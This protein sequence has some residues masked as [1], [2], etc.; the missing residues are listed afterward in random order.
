MQEI[1]ISNAE[2]EDE[3]EQNAKFCHELIAQGSSHSEAA[4]I[5]NEISK[6]LE[7]LEEA[8]RQNSSAENAAPS[9]LP[10]NAQDQN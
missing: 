5:L 8:A 10:S 2:L 4:V 7:H 9:S 3:A 1:I 6:S